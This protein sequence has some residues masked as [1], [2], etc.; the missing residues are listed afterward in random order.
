MSQSS[1]P[2]QSSPVQAPGQLSS[3][4]QGVYDPGRLDRRPDRTQDEQPELP[5]DLPRSEPLVLDLPLGL[6]AVLTPGEPDPWSGPTAEDLLANQRRWRAR[7][8]R[9]RNQARREAAALDYAAG[10]AWAARHDPTDPEDTA[11]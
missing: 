6:H 5:L 11:S 4:V 3:P 8:S 10:Q 9:A 2:A 7:L 1:S